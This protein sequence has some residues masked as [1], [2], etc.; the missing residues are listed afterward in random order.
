ME[1]A[2]AIGILVFVLAG[3]VGFSAAVGVYASRSNRSF[4]IYFF[5]SLIVSPIP[6]FFLVVILNL[7]SGLADSFDA[8]PLDG[9]SKKADPLKD[10]GAPQEP[11]VVETD[12]A[13]EPISEEPVKETPIEKD[14]NTIRWEGEE[15]V[16]CDNCYSRID[17]SATECP[18]CGADLGGSGWFS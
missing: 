12:V 2:V 13:E 8:G 14:R 4:L 5:L 9:S 11:D 1:D 10:Q 3:Y 17:K 15:K 6:I 16:R 7:A 18:A